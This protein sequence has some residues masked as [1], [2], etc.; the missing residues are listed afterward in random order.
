MDRLPL[1]SGAIGF[2]GSKTILPTSDTALQ[3]PSRRFYLDQ[4]L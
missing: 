1:P 3:A 4:S 2:E